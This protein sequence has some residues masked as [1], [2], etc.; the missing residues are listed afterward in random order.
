MSSFVSFAYLFCCFE[1]FILYRIL[2]KQNMYVHD[3]RQNSKLVE[4]SWNP[5]SSLLYPNFGCLRI[6]FTF[7]IRMSNNFI[8]P[9]DTIK[10]ANKKNPIH[11]F[12][13]YTNKKFLFKL[14][15]PLFFQNDSKSVEIFNQRTLSKW[16]RI[17][18]FLLPFYL[19]VLWSIKLLMPGT[20]HW[21]NKLFLRS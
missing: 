14:K 13:S 9:I 20:F 3:R 1:K 12:M 16:F 10:K 15:L 2:K 4:Y 11:L 18:F 21:T 19:F 8:T 7:I 6:F 17:L 5:F